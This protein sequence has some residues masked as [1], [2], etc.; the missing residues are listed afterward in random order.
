[1]NNLLRPHAVPLITF[2]RYSRAPH[3]KLA[4]PDDLSTVVLG[5]RKASIAYPKPGI[6]D[7][8]LPIH[9]KWDRPVMMETVNPQISGD[10]G[11]LDHFGKVDL[12]QPPVGLENSK[13]LETAPEDVKR[14]LSLEFARR[15]DVLEKLSR[16][17]LKTVQKHPRDFDSLEVRITLATIKIRNVQ[18]ELIK[19]Y[20]YKN[21]PAKHSLSHKISSRRKMLR[22]LRE[23]DYKKYEWLL[24]KLN[25]LYKPMPHDAPD[26]VVIPRENIERK[27][28]IE[29]L[30]DLWCE[31]LKRH[32]LNAYKRQLVRE[33]P[34]FLIRKAEKLKHILKEEKDMGLEPTVREEEIEEC[35]KKAEEIQAKLDTE[36]TMED[37]EY[38]IYNNEEE[39]K[40]NE[41]TYFQAIDSK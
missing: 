23:Q 10:I 28:S 9:V 31:E 5:K 19:L 30:T 29:R 2:V 40:K 38:L 6:S 36:G 39:T 26:G 7:K 13:V 34:G 3:R 12:A 27:A 24:E 1:M 22:N 21:Q 8:A 41:H 17:V 18:E 33:Q 16:D 15:R 37:D 11:G 14:V 32:R 25:L 35:L 20:P 4:K